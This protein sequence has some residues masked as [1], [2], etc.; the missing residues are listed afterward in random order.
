MV[1]SYIIS[2]SLVKFWGIFFFFLAFVLLSTIIMK[3]PQTGK[4]IK[5]KATSKSDS[6]RFHLKE[7]RKRGRM[8]IGGN[9]VGAEGKSQNAKIQFT[10]VLTHL[11]S[12]LHARTHE[13]TNSLGLRNGTSLQNFV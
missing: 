13:L 7:G 10:L 1:T 11:P 8:R 3:S 4:G 2:G 12:F 9:R 5:G 6:L